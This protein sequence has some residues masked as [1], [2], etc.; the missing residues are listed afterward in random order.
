M[1]HVLLAAVLVSSGLILG[2][3]Q[4]QSSVSGSVTLM[5]FEEDTDII[6]G[7]PDGQVP[8][9]WYKRDEHTQHVVGPPG[10]EF[11]P[12]PCRGLAISWNRLVSLQG[13]AAEGRRTYIALGQLL[14]R[15]AAHNCNASITRDTSTDPQEVI[16]IHPT[17]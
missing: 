13:Q 2:A 17:P 9:G 3:A 8:L 16:S 10:S 14:S 11:P 7:Y 1:R 12:S 4:P 6:I 5:D 15:M